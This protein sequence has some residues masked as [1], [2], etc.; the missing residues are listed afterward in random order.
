MAEN[1][2]AQTPAATPPVESPAAQTPAATPP[3]ESP[4]VESRAAQAPAATLPAERAHPSGWA[5]GFTAF[6]SCVMVMLGVFQMMAGLAALF[7]N[8]LYAVTPTYV[9]KLDVTAWGWIH[10]LLGILIFAAGLG[11]FAGQVWARVLGVGLALLS[12]IATF[13]YLPY[14]PFWSVVIIALAIG[15]IWALTAHGRDITM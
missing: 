7:E 13:A 3:V 10:L 9:F 2:S 14:Y 4:A 11:L 15:V 6:A 12:A 5:I 8:E 1:P